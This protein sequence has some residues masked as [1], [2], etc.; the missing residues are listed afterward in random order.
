MQTKIYVT[1]GDGNRLPIN[2]RINRFISPEGLKVRIKSKH[3]LFGFERDKKGFYTAESDKDTVEFNLKP[4][5]VGKETFLPTICIATSKNTVVGY[6]IGMIVTK[7][8]YYLCLVEKWTA[9]LN[10][11]NGTISGINFAALCDEL[12]KDEYREKVENL[13]TVRNQPPPNPEF[14]EVS[15]K[16]WDLEKG[17]GVGEIGK[18]KNREKVLLRDENFEGEMDIPFLFPGTIVMCGLQRNRNEHW[19]HLG[20]GIRVI[21]PN[22]IGSLFS[23][24]TINELLSNEAAVK[25]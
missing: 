18:G 3:I 25:A 7:K 2:E 19:D 22:T 4:V 1:D 14:G 20:T 21:R 5:Q 13:P 23:V 24:E 10:Y 17:Y 8:G 15:V 12:R 16:Y 11:E 9:R 6:K